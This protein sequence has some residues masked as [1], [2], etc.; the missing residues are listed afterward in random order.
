MPSPSFQPSPQP[1]QPS[2]RRLLGGAAAGLGLLATSGCPRR[3][4]SGQ[5]GPAGTP[6]PDPLLADL[7]GAR[8]MVDLYDATLRTHPGLAHRLGPLRANHAA[9]VDAL[10]AAVGG[11]AGTPSPSGTPSASPSAAAVPASPAAALATLRRA[12]Q[13]AGAGLARSAVRSAGGRAALLASIAAGSAGHEVV[14][15]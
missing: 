15:S 13:A 7:A 9:H 14:L 5:A 6:E 2:R 8:R 11:A 1:S 4:V 10:V 12:E 3:V